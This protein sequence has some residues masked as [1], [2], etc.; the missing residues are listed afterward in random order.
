MAN[1]I[2]SFKARAEPNELIEVRALIAHPM[3]T[4]FRTNDSGKL[5]ARNIIES[6]TCHY[7][8]ALVIDMKL[9]PSIAANPYIR[10]FVRA[11]ST[12]PLEFVWRGQ[13]GFEQREIRTLT[14]GS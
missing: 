2:I 12:G 9:N 8:E 7:G 4:G 6:F 1:S 13:Q 10:F 14:V 11:Q 5:V 3:E